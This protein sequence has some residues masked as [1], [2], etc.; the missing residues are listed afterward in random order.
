VKGPGAVMTVTQSGDTIT[1]PATPNFK[2][3][4]RTLTPGPNGFPPAQAVPPA[5]SPAN[6]SPLIKLPNGTVLNAPTIANS[7]GQAA[8]VVKLDTSGMK[9]Q[10]EET[11]GRYEDKHVHYASF[12][13]ANPV[14]ASIENTTLTPALNNVPKPNDEGQKTSA[15]EQLDAFVNGPTGLD[16]PERQGENAAVLDS[17]DPFNLLHETPELPMHPD[18]GS[19]DYTPMWDVHLARWTD[20]AVSAGSRTQLQVVDDVLARIKPDDMG[21]PATITAPDGTPFTASG[22]VVNCPLI[23]LDIP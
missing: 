3:G 11:E 10:Y 22:F 19:T 13:G 17:H 5:T 15:R 16:N 14:V 2:P 9:V 23:S 12:D 7:T 1:F 20:A 6:Y 18:V 4:T 21:N 8:K